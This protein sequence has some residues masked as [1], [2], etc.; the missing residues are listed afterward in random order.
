VIRSFRRVRAAGT[1]WQFD[2][3]SGIAFVTNWAINNAGD[4]RHTAYVQGT[5]A[6]GQTFVGRDGDGRR[7]PRHHAAG[8]AHEPVGRPRRRP[9]GAA[10]V[11][12]P[13]VLLE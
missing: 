1:P 8:Q 13:V 2:A 5:G 6:F 12:E 11:A 7:H 3:K 10:A 4:G 9:E